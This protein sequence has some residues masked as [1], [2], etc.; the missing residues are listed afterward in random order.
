M[1]EMSIILATFL[2]DLALGGFLGKK[3]QVFGID[4]L[5]LFDIKLVLVYIF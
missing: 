5:V 4:L 2:L 1:L 3:S